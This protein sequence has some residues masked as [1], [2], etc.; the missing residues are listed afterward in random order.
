MKNL[1]PSSKE[2]S[3]EVELYHTSTNHSST[4]PPRSSVFAVP[5]ILHCACTLNLKKT[6]MRNY[7]IVDGLYLCSDY[8]FSN[9]VLAS[10]SLTNSTLSSC[11]ILRQTLPVFNDYPIGGNALRTLGDRR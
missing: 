10:C 9:V 3:L 11:F 6:C 4:N 5:F 8:S 2:P 7:Q 1:T